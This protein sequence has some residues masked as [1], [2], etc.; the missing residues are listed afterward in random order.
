[1]SFACRLW[2]SKTLVHRKCS[3]CHHRQSTFGNS[4]RH[5]CTSTSCTSSCRARRRTRTV[6]LVLTTRPRVLRQNFD[7]VTTQCSLA[8]I[9]CSLFTGSIDICVTVELELVGS[10]KPRT[11][12]LAADGCPFHLQLLGMSFVRQQMWRYQ[13]LEQSPLM[14]ILAACTGLCAVDT[15]V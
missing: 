12:N 11:A 14:S 2:D 7:T 13:P 3:S 10:A 8:L 4:L 1:M 15:E 6:S 9:E 5:H